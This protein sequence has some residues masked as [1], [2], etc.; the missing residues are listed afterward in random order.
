MRDHKYA[1]DPDL[2]GRCAYC[3]ASRARRPGEVQGAAQCRGLDARERCARMGVSAR[4]L[5]DCAMAVA[6]GI[7]FALQTSVYMRLS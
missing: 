4:A 6:E 1:E 7:R 3:L 5:A 2:E